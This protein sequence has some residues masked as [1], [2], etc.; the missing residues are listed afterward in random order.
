MLRNSVKQQTF[1][2]R[3]IHTPEHTYTI[4]QKEMK[5][6]TYIYF[7]PSPTSKRLESNF[8]QLHPKLLDIDSTQKKM[9][10]LIFKFGGIYNRL[11]KE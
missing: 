10:L 8:L 2:K 6:I 9:S 1:I 7:T 5:V 3:K 11:D 4:L